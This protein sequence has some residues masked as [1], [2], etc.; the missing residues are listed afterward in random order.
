MLDADAAL[1]I[2]REFFIDTLITGVTVV[3]KNGHPVIQVHGTGN[4]DQ[5]KRATL[6]LGRGDAPAK[7]NRAAKDLGQ[8]VVDGIVAELD[9]RQVSEAKVW[10][11]R[12]VVEHEN[13]KMR[14]ARFL[15]ELG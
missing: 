13:G 2:D 8:P 15:L 10:T 5:F 6:E 1:S 11:L 7:W 14:E 12:L 4:A 9:A 3:M